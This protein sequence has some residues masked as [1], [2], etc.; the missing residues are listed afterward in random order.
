MAENQHVRRITLTLNKIVILFLTMFIVVPCVVDASVLSSL[1]YPSPDTPYLDNYLKIYV[2]H[3]IDWNGIAATSYN[4][5]L[6]L[7]IVAED[8]DGISTVLLM[9]ENK[10]DGVWM[11]ETMVE[12]SVNSE[13]RTSVDFMLNRTIP[14]D[15]DWYHVKYAS[16]D[17]LG[18]W[19]VTSEFV[20]QLSAIDPETGDSII[21]FLDTMDVQYMLGETGNFIDWMVD[22]ITSPD[23][24]LHYRLEK[25]G[26]LIEYAPWTHD[27]LLRT[28]V[29]GL[30]VGEHS[31]LLSVSGGISSD[32]SQATVH[33]TPIP[34]I[35]DLCF[36]PTITIVVLVSMI[37]ISLIVIYRRRHP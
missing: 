1:Q 33:V 34:E 19:A 37:A 24:D 6:D 22:P 31:Y 5:T 8:P 12:G 27:R 29:D 32:S 7:E 16:N 17:S 11:N 23:S 2:D 20:Y 25:D 9:Y 30:C 10:G 15:S 14:Y 18:N 4:M 36:V 21:Q 3:Y 35:C 28:S 13:Y 26:Y